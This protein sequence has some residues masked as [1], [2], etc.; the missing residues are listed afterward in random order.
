LLL[1]LLLLLL[2]AW[3]S[4]ALVPIAVPAFQQAAAAAPHINVTHAC[5]QSHAPIHASLPAPSGTQK[6]KERQGGV[7][8]QQPSV[9]VETQTTALA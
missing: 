4:V 8:N 5:Q 9:M 2:L 3:H 7:P 6:A 1:L